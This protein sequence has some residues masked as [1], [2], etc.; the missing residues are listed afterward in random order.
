MRGS[1][2]SLS[3]TIK[4]LEG[5]LKSIEGSVAPDSQLH[6]RLS[7]MLGNV[8]DAAKSL[9]ELADELT[10]NPNALIVGKKERKN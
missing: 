6:Y 7:D 1:N 10:R 9:E 3:T 5:T 2:S 8:S 4:E